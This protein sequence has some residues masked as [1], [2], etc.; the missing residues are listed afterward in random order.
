M[1]RSSMT[2]LLLSAVPA[3]A[4][5]LVQ[6]NIHAWRTTEHDDNLDALCTELAG[7]QPDILC[8]NEVLPRI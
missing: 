6:Y 8:L 7:L 1:V 3:A 2:L 5:R 4:L